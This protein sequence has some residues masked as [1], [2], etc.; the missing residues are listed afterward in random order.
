MD[1]KSC[2]DTYNVELQFNFLNASIF[3]L[4][5]INIYVTVEFYL[6][7]IY[8]LFTKIKSIEKYLSNQQ[9][10]P[11]NP[12]ILNSIS[13]INKIIKLVNRSL[14]VQVMLIIF[15]LFIFGLVLIFSITLSISIG[16]KLSMILD[17]LSSTVYAHFIIFQISY[18]GAKT[19]N[20][21]FIKN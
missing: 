10:L 7:I 18:Y 4:N 15:G 12:K 20:E 3:A 2:Y 8:L 6:I 11:Y 13:T 19:K 1:T 17:F 9:N 21:V 5:I 16:S 14:S